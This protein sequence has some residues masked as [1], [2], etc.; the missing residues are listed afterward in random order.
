MILALK[1]TDQIDLIFWFHSLV[2]TYIYYHFSCQGW[3]MVS[4]QVYLHF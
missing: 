2:I 1:W 4:P 3:I